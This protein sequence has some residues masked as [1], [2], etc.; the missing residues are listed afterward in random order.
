VVSK[1]L[2]HFAWIR[3]DGR[4]VVSRDAKILERDTVRVQQ[5]ED[6][7]IGLNEERRGLRERY[8]VRQNP[9]ID[10]AVR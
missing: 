5:A 7:V 9:R 1:A 10:V 4:P 8:V 6:V 3:L 2:P